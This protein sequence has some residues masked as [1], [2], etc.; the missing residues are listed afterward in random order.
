MFKNILLP[1]DGSETSK[2]ALTAG[3]AFAKETGAA[4]TGFYVIPNFHVIT[5][6]TEM[7]EDT[8][9]EF[10]KAGLERAKHYLAEVTDA[11]AAAGVKCDTYFVSG[12][13]PYEAIIEAVKEKHCDLIIMASHGRRGVKGLLLGSETQKVLTH[14]TIPVLVYR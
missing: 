4:V 2:I 8:R 9:A 12:D 14:S 10:E 7:L 5:Y 6:Q 13:Y 11:A 3:V 1:I